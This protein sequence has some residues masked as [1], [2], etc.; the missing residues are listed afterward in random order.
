MSFFFVNK[1]S[2][3]VCYDPNLRIYDD[4]ARPFY[5]RDEPIKHRFNLPKGLYFTN[6]DLIPK[7][8]PFE[9]KKKKL[10]KPDKRGVLPRGFKVVFKPNSNKCT[11]YIP[12]EGISKKRVLIV[13]DPSLKELPKYFLVFIFFHELGHFYYKGGTEKNESKCDDFAFNKMLDKGYNISQIVQACKYTLSER[14]K[15]RRQTNYKRGLKTK[16]K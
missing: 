4:S 2:G 13:A 12:K 10:P 9:F 1:K 8:S 15:K 3:F 5:F 11:V 14:Q 6:N 7:K 16:I